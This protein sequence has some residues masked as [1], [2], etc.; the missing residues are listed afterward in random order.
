MHVHTSSCLLSKRI[1]KATTDEGER[2]GCERLQLQSIC[3]C[4]QKNTPSFKAQ[5]KTWD[6]TCVWAKAKVT[7]G[8]FSRCFLL[9]CSRDQTFL[10]T[11][12]SV[13]QFSELRRKVKSWLS[14]QPLFLCCPDWRV[15]R[16]ALVS[17]VGKIW[18]THIFMV[19]QEN[20][21]P[22]PGMT[23]MP[24]VLTQIAC[25]LV[26]HGGEN[27]VAWDQINKERKSPL[28]YGLKKWS[29]HTQT[30]D[31]SLQQKLVESSYHQWLW[32][33]KES[34]C[35]KGTASIWLWGEWICR[36]AM[37]TVN[38]ITPLILP[39]SA[40]FPLPT[41]LPCM[42]P[43]WRVGWARWRLL[44]SGDEWH[45][46]W[47]RCQSWISISFVCHCNHCDWGAMQHRG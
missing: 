12:H 32:S 10:V 42:L 40:P 15:F 21:S 36:F 19:L 41:S 3:A 34:G 6:L 37:I 2:E 8:K 28:I 17:V 38:E 47:L 29:I 44:F 31:F 26:D 1:E 27:P 43:L 22:L 24:L 33:E 9:S 20:P 45:A 16:K 23:S 14:F 25:I 35:L 13:S 5:H 18:Q 30:R 11:L 46:E 4:T 39:L 7:E